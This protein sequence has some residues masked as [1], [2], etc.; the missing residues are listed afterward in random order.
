MRR[1]RTQILVEVALTVAMAAVLYG[2]FHLLL[3]INAF[4]GE[5]AFT[6]VPIMVLSLRRGVVPG[7][8]AGALFG[9]FMLAVEPYIVHPAQVLLDYPVAFGLVGLTGLGSRAYRRAVAEGRTARAA[10]IAA[11]SA[12]LG[13]AGRFAAHVASGVVFFAANAPQGQ[14]VF[15]YS[16]AYN[17]TYVVPSAA[18][19][20]PAAVFVALAL[21]RAVP[22]TTVPKGA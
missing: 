19:C 16:L 11:V 10:G 3:P 9:L 4:G 20:I 17:A 18:L 6:M 5:I 8:V 7:I 13:A 14:P 1:A 22:V 15:L 21:E 2:L 12:L